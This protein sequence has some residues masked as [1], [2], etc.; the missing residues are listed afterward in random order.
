M[1]RV[2]LVFFVLFVDR[3]MIESEVKFLMYICKWG[4]KVVF[5]VNKMDLFFDFGDVDEVVVFVKENV[6][7]LFS[8]SDFAVFFV[9]S[10][11]VFKAKK[12]DLLNYVNLCVFVESGF[13]K[14]EDYVMLFLGGLGECVGEV[15]WFKFLMLFNVSEFLFNVVE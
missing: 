12:A 1:S 9:S 3:F 6:M 10:R 14:F 7:W 13:G 8:V 4:K 2:D 5:V 15:L 11:N